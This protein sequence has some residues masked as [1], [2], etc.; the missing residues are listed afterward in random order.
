[1]AERV[2]VIDGH[3]HAGVRHFCRALADGYAAGAEARGAEVMRIDV[4]AIAPLP[5]TDP[6]DFARPAEGAMAEAQ[7]KVLAARHLAIVF[8][9][10]LGTMPA[11]FKAFWEQLARA[12]FALAQGAGRWPEGRLRGRS[13]RIVVTM[14]MPALAFRLLW[15]AAGVRSL[16]AGILGIA[17]VSP[18][19]T[20]YIGG[21]DALKPED[22]AAWVARVE[23]LGRAFA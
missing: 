13:A 11:Q 7:E 17:G 2:A 12:D 8:P 18:V 23:A 10:W 21:V 16:R 14:G 15:G 20:T 5:L 9:L 19:R 1:M 3:P 4:A 6:A 22:R